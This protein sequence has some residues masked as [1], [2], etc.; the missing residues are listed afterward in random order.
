MIE[1]TREEKDFLIAHKKELQR[2]DFERLYFDIEGEFGSPF[3]AYF[4][5]FFLE[6]NVDPLKY[7]KV[8]VP[9]YAFYGV[10]MNYLLSELTIK[11]GIRAIGYKAFSHNIEMTRL[12]LPSSLEVIGSCAFAGC[13]SL[14]E[15]HFH[16]TPEIGRKIF[17]DCFA[18][19]R[20]YVPYDKNMSSQ[21]AQKYEEQLLARN[22]A[23]L[24][25]V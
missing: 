6:H 25:W 18:L 16:S 10:N 14:E 15:V 4:S 1:L 20:V 11:E 23:I 21:E 19:K 24:E 22:N 13:T 12:I 8:T 9:P 7:L 17:V 2:N 3:T 5:T